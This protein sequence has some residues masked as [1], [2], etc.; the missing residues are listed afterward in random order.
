MN[1][2]GRPRLGPLG[3]AKNDPAQ[4]DDARD[5]QGRRSGSA[6]SCSTRSTTIAGLAGHFRG[7]RG[8]KRL[9]RSSMS[10]SGAHFRLG[11]Q[12]RVAPPG[13]AG[14]T[15]VGPARRGEVGRPLVGSPGVGL[16]AIAVGPCFRLNS[17]SKPKKMACLRYSAERRCILT[18]HWP[19]TISSATAATTAIIVRIVSRGLRIGGAP[20]SGAQA[21]RARQGARGSGRH[22]RTCVAACRDSRPL[23]DTAPPVADTRRPPKGRQR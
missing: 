14:G 12:D 13:I 18:A 7:A 19:P 1:T 23:L 16:I 9:A 3:G 6:K 22:G 4:V 10:R 5:Q 11:R 17:S 20:S 15:V 8:W 21:G 2:S